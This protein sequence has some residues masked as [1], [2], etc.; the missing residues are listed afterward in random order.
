MVARA[1]CGAA[2]AVLTMVSACG[3]DVTFWVER[4][5]S[6]QSLTQGA[7][8]LAD[9]SSEGRY[10]A[11]GPH[12]V[13]GRVP[14]MAARGGGPTEVWEARMGAPEVAEIAS[15]IDNGGRMYLDVDMLSLGRG[16][17]QLWDSFGNQASTLE[18]DTRDIADATY[19]TYDDLIVGRTEGE[20]TVPDDSIIR[21]VPGFEATLPVV[22]LDEDG[23][24][25]TGEGLLDLR[26]EGGNRMFSLKNIGPGEVAGIDTFTI[27]AD[28]LTG[29]DAPKIIV[30][31]GTENPIHEVEVQVLPPAAVSEIQLEMI[32]DYGPFAKLGY[33]HAR[34]VDAN[35]A[36]MIGP[37]LQWTA[38]GVTLSGLGSFVELE[39]GCTETITACVPDTDV[40]GSMVVEGKARS[41]GTS[42]PA[43]CGCA[44][45]NGEGFVAWTVMLLALAWTRRRK[46]RQGGSAVLVAAGLAALLWAPTASAQDLP[47]EL[48]PEDAPAEEAPAEPAPDTPAEP[49][50]PAEEAPAGPTAAELNQAREPDEVPPTPTGKP[51]FGFRVAPS[52][53]LGLHTP[54][55]SPQPIRYNAVVG[56]VAS[57]TYEKAVN[58]VG[59]I[60][61]TSIVGNWMIGTS[62][63]GWEAR[64]ASVFG[65]RFGTKPGEFTVSFAP[66]LGLEFLVDN[67]NFY[68]RPFGTAFQIGVPIMARLRLAIVVMEGGVVP[69]WF[70]YTPGRQKVDWNV[71]DVKGFGDEFEARVG[72]SLM[73]KKF[74]I[75]VS[76]RTRFASYGDQTWIGIGAG[77]AGGIR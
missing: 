45:T 74:R 37:M 75:G 17:L 33:L 8:E 41:V 21:M 25:L 56:G 58:P 38:N 18:F 26:V 70:L 40:C 15:R 54:L 23:R 43:R 36:R 14:I 39:D 30:S 42:T 76:M 63:W 57:F 50:A 60:G 3:P 55:Q 49:E 12:A 52:L 34:A 2:L 71:S 10:I 68:C 24:A 7:I 28:R 51:T 61:A 16:I 53:A 46:E 22:W 19:V 35:G 64:V 4:D 59:W 69:S 73:I 47:T 13:G 72:I 48:P 5:R 6:P 62:R 65:P 31:A 67:Y 1:R 32:I 29:T 77:Y 27:R 44:Q 9:P 66:L 20:Q 11:A